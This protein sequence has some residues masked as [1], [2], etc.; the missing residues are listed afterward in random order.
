MTVTNRNFT[1]NLKNN[2]R[3]L[4]I[5]QVKSLGPIPDHKRWICLMQ[6]KN[7]KLLM[8][9]MPISMPVHRARH[10][11]HGIKGAAIAATL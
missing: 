2:I 4:A 9:L 11:I 10:H 6:I 5:G 3:N 7:H 1:S 8:C